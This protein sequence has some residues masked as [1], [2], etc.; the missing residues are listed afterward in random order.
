M[1]ELRGFN[2]MNAV[3][4][5]EIEGVMPEESDGYRSVVIRSSY[6]TSSEFLCD[7]IEVVDLVRATPDGEVR[8]Q[9]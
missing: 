3:F 1:N 7:S 4:E 9:P 6:G 8:A 5:L 2:Y